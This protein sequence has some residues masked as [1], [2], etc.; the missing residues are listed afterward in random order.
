[1]HMVH[2]KRSKLGNTYYVVVDTETGKLVDF[3]LKK[4]EAITISN[5]LDGVEERP[6]E[7]S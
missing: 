2:R 6:E 7:S 4:I 5:K 1:M 3:A